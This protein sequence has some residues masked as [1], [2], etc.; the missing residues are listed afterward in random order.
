MLVLRRKIGEE[1]C[2]GDGIIVKVLAINGR[3]IRL[4]IK[5]PNSIPIRRGEFVNLE[6]G[7]KHLTPGH[8]PSSA[9]PIPCGR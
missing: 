7:D 3:A 6:V 9:P 4:G 2:L 1:I 8:A 5:A